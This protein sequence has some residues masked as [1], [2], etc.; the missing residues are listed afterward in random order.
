MKFCQS[1]R[2]AVVCGFFVCLLF[3]W[4]VF[5]MFVSWKANPL[6]AIASNSSGGGGCHQTVSKVYP[7]D[8]LPAACATHGSI[9]VCSFILF[10]TVLCYVWLKVCLTGMLLSSDIP[11]RPLWFTFSNSVNE[12]ASQLCL[13]RSAVTQSSQSVKYVGEPHCAALPLFRVPSWLSMPLPSEAGIQMSCPFQGSGQAVA[14]SR[15]LSSLH[16]TP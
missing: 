2:D 15:T 8:D 10:D 13:L 14:R 5:C 11:G 16:C 12:L 6:F 7:L 3:V 4:L 1:S 9:W